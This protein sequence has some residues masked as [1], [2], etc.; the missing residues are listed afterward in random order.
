MK[1]QI[2][3]LL[4]PILPIMGYAQQVDS[5]DVGFRTFH[6]QDL[7]GAVS[8]VNVSELT[9]KNYMTY[10]L[11]YMQSMV[12]GYNGGLWNQGEALVLIDGVPRD[13]GNL[14]PE[15][16]ESITFLKS[17]Q[18]VVLYGS[19]AAKGAILINTKRGKTDGLQVKVGGSANIYVPK[20][21]PKYLGSAQYMTLYNEALRNDG[22]EPVYSQEDIYHYANHDNDYRYPEI[23][24][25]SSDYVKKTY[26]RYNADAEF[27]GGG[28]FA[29]FY[30][31]VGFYNIGDLIK[32][33]EGKKNHTNRLS[34]R[35]NVDLRLNDWV[36]GW[37][38]ADATFYDSRND[39]ANYWAESANI[40]PTSQNP[41]VPFIPVSAIDPNDENSNILAANSNN[42]IDGKYLL[43]GTQLQMTNPFAAMYAAGY[44]KYTSR[45]VQFDAGIKLD[46]RKVLDGLSFK[47]H[48]GMDYAS[49]YNTK[50][51]KDYSTYEAIWNNMNGVDQI[52]QLLKYGTDKITGKQDLN[53]S[54]YKQTILFNA[55]FDYDHSFGKHHVAGTL[56]ANG[57]QQTFTGEYHRTSN[58]NLGLQLNWNYAH[59]YYAD[60]S[61]AAIHS[62]KLAEGHRE[63]I[64]PV[65]SLG[66]RLSNEK[67]L[68]GAKWLD[69]LKLTTSYGVINQDIDIPSY[70]MYDYVF[71]ATGQWWGWSETAQTM[72]TSLSTRG[73]NKNL[74]FVKRKE[75]RIGLESQLFKG[76][77][78]MDINYFNVKQNDQIVIPSIQYPSFFA[79]WNT[80]FLPNANYN[81]QT[82][83]G[84][85]YTININKKVG[86]IDLSVGLTGMYYWSKND[87]I[88]EN[89][90]Y[91]W[92]NATGTAIETL[93]GY[94]CLGYFQESDFDENGNTTLPVINANTKPGDL[95]YEDLNGDGII[96][97]RDQ[98]VLGKWQAPFICGLNLTAKYKNFTLFVAGNGNFGGKGMKGNK[99]YWVYGTMK[100]SDVQLGR[101]TP[102]TAET[103]TFPRLTT[104]NGDL[105]FVSSDYWMFNTS[106]FY[107]QR[108]Q[109]TYDF[110]GRLFDTSFVK[111]LQVYAYGTDLLCISPERKYLETSVGGS[112]QCRS[113]AVGVKVNF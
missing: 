50:I 21:Y 5:V 62:A 108:V 65:V 84:I 63:A 111:G 97:Y 18:A 94:H 2:M 8:S 7:M 37:V 23:N 1:Q 93:R 52:T 112:P 30:T 12:G 39:L 42:L 64:S 107:L 10:S 99:L 78:K 33:G 61:M 35:G 92:L 19:R 16:V 77:V 90:E 67:W 66:W 102:E 76:L 17:A 60:L 86:D 24:F 47:T 71:T 103:A 48:F 80:T 49:S 57:Y 91:S 83:S 53:G 41:L 27:Q 20:R 36:T 3:T 98:K 46:L 59:T 38:D 110:P 9:K 105:N 25:F 28:K 58:A 72:Q 106:A 85:D 55:Q 40:R 34:L 73:A 88:S 69:D 70:Y 31:Y 95:K 29:H 75:F 81:N 6:K 43:G 44:N 89:N 15:E 45:Q 32:F 68:S 56:L 104:G 4:L 26:Q 74:G 101:W 113:Y 82:R 100:Y 96:D 11:D 79:A 87:R 13:A 51:A 109:F 14:S 54:Y 22:Y